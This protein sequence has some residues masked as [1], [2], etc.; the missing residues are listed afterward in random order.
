M[1]MVYQTDGTFKTFV[2][3]GNEIEQGL[4]LVANAA[5]AVFKRIFQSVFGFLVHY[6]IVSSPSSLRQHRLLLLRLYA[7]GTNDGEAFSIIFCFEYT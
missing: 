5:L 7:C 2:Q 3:L 6:F 4:C 1:A